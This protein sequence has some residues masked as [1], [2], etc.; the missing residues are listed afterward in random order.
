MSVYVDALMS[1]VPC[2][3]WRYDKACHLFADD[4]GELHL[5][6]E[7]LGLKKEWFQDRR[8]FK[9]YD[10]TEPK[11]IAALKAVSLSVTQKFTFGFMKHN[12]GK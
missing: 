11:Q 2:A 9:H 7:K 10:L 12:R 1:V 6:A 5:F 3:N 8:H 4:I